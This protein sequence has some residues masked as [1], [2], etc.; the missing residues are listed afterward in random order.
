MMLFTVISIP[1]TD[2]KL[3]RAFHFTDADLDANRNG[4]LSARQARGLRWRFFANMGVFGMLTVGLGVLGVLAVVYG[5]YMVTLWVL[6]LDSVFVFLLRRQYRNVNQA[7]MSGW[8]ESVRGN[9]TLA[10]RSR[11]EGHAH[12][13]MTVPRVSVNGMAFDITEGQYRALSEGGEYS[14]YY[15]LGVGMIVSVERHDFA[16]P[17]F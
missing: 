10:R 5:I 7:V 3:K 2:D 11:D 8:V 15:L 6:L 1:A 14:V 16:L 9:A 17:F 12:T 13:R 4:Q